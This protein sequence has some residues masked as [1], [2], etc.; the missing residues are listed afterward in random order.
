MGRLVCATGRLRTLEEILNHKYALH[1]S[2]T[3]AMTYFHHANGANAEV[4]KDQKQ[5]RQIDTV[6]ITSF[7]SHICCGVFSVAGFKGKQSC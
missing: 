1:V 2:M 3:L 4:S 6:R 5:Q 7:Q